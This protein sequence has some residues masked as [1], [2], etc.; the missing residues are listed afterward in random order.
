MQILSAL[1]GACCVALVAAAGIANAAALSN[2]DRQFLITVAKSD[3]TEAHEGQ[4]AEDQASRT[5]VKDFGKTLVQD[6]TQSYEHLA[7]L[8][9]KTGVSIPKGIDTAKDPS[10]QRLAHLKGSRFESAFDSDEIG[11]HKRALAL[12]KREAANGQ[13]ADV[14]AFASNMIPVLEKHLQLAEQCAKAVNKTK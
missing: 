14:K 1:S 2:A 12:F 3:M 13:D 11:S 4:M 5:D 6:H 9:A 7:E 8:A 10:I